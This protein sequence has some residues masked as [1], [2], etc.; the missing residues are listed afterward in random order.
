[1]VTKIAP[2]AQKI[3]ASTSQRAPRTSTMWS[4]SCRRLSNQNK[5][6]CTSWTSRAQRTSKKHW[7]TAVLSDQIRKMKLKSW[8]NT[9]SKKLNKLESF[10]ICWLINM[11]ITFVRN[12][13]QGWSMSIRSCCS[14]ICLKSSQA[15]RKIS[16]SCCPRNCMIEQR[17]SQSSFGPPWTLKEHTPFK[18]LSKT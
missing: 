15:R 1:M 8:F 12:F 11:A 7:T 13:F 17:Q 6:W 2:S 4:I 9:S 5:C 18:S 3:A 16:D 14:K 10:Q